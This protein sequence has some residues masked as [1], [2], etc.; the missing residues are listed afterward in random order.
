MRWVLWFVIGAW[1]IFLSAMAVLH[2][3]I[4][5][6]IGELRPELEIRASQA[7]GIPLRIGSIEARPGGIFPSFQLDNV[8]LLDP[9]GHDALRLPRVM[10][11]V[12]PTS[13]WNLG[14]EHL[15]IDSPQL[16]IRRTA[17]GR[18]YV[19]GLDVSKDQ[20]SDGRAADWFFSQNE[21]VIQNGSVDWTDELRNM[22]TLTLEQVN[23]VMQNDLRSHEMRLDASPPQA[24]SSR[25]SVK[26]KFSQPLLQSHAGQWRDWSGQVYATFDRVDV[27]QLR[28]HANV[29]LA[30][31]TGQGAVRAWIDIARGQ[32]RGATADVALSNASLTLGRELDILA[33]SQ[34][35]GRFS[36][37][38]VGQGF[39]FSTAD[40]AFD[41]EDGLHWPGGNLSGVW[42]PAQE[43][44]PESGEFKAN[45]LDLSAL[46]QIAKRLPLDARV[47]EALISYAPKGL[48]EQL[49]ATWQ[50]APHALSK[51]EIKA[52]VQQLSVAAQAAR[53]VDSASHDLGATPVTRPPLGRPGVQGA[54][55][56]VTLNQSGGQATV[57]MQNGQVEF[58]GVFEKP[59]IEL[60]QLAAEVK[61][62][63]KEDALSVQ[64]PKLKFANADAQ[65]E[66]Q[67][68]WHTSQAGPGAAHTVFPGVLDM[69][70][71]LTRAN[72]A[73]LYRYLPVHIQQNVRDYLRDAITAGHATGVNFK[74]KGNLAD[75]PFSDPHQGEF[76]VSGLASD[77]AYAY[78]PRTQQAKEALPWPALSQA[79]GE[80]KFQGNS[81]TLKNVTARIA[82]ANS[83]QILHGGAAIT[84][85]A[86]DPHV[87]VSL[88]AQGPL[89]DLLRAG[90][91]GSPLG[92]MLGQTLSQARATGNAEL[93]L[94]LELP[95][96]ALDS[97]KVQGKVKLLSNEVQLSKDMPWLS[98]TSGVVHFS[99]QG[100]ALADAT[101]RTLGGEVRAEGG[102]IAIPGKQVAGASPLLRIQGTL[103]AE[104]LRQA[105]ELGL[106]SQLA[107]QASGK[108]SYT[109]SLNWRRGLPEW[110][111]NSSLQGL[112]LSLP[113]PLTKRAESALPLRLD[114]TPTGEPRQD[115]LSLDIG[116]AVL[117]RYVRDL[118]GPD[119]KVLRGSVAV[120]LPVGE[121][122]ALPSQGVLA[123]ATLNRLDVDAL[124][125]LM[126]RPSNTPVTPANA[127]SEAIRSYLPSSVVVQANE[128]IAGGHTFNH[129]VAG[130][131]RSGRAWQANVDATE[132]S[133]YVEYTESTD[134]RAGRVYARL[135]RLM[136]A[137]SGASEVE[138]LLDEQPVSIPTLDVVVDELELRGK[139]LGRLEMEAVNRGNASRD[140]GAREWRLNKLNVISREASF[141][142]TG[143]WSVLN[144]PGTTARAPGARVGRERRR[145]VMNFKMNVDDA[146]GML[147][148]IGMKDV[149]RRGNGFME[150]QVSWMGSPMAL[151]YPS[152][153]GAFNVNIEN[154]QFLKA[155][156][157]AA[158]LLG[159]LNLQA[160]PRRLTL[161]F[162]DVFSDG[163]SFDYVRG[164]VRIDQGI[165]STQNL[166]MQGVNAAVF[167]EGRADIARETQDIK[168]VVVPEINAG[169]ASLI[170][171][172][173]NP[174]VGLSTF[175][176]QLILR[177]PLIESNTQ[178]FKLTGTWADPIIDR[179]DLSKEATTPAK[180]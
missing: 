29:T 86:H 176:A 74:V 161:D 4:V 144:E 51:Y 98:R 40:M 152:L 141:I 64:V 78:V 149:F 68:S 38:R 18:I 94:K 140:A 139:K 175:L 145:T 171:G 128:V 33:M 41:T 148:R 16:H 125:S 119:A 67:A 172:W 80:F 23:L 61:W 107:Q 165:A 168:V 88:E 103:T 65:G 169:T 14:F 5:P 20:N 66:A 27:A 70:G 45:R 160:L 117:V 180:P 137:S 147:A 155:D 77:V 82:N 58:P 153:S 166:Q 173:A 52:R 142:A 22:P 111:V 112:S 113:Q 44:E 85:M 57:S 158:K 127:S 110:S 146:G 151:D 93:Q 32:L 138:N 12:S 55:L 7:L 48:V 108:T 3:V 34:F 17:Q 84:D 90:V 126:G 164:N 96:A 62:Q 97:T 49:Q 130:A 179:I 106:V 159:V 95:L 120:G 26:A 177:K 28:Q 170:A 69:Q 39:A 53:R 131:S 71:T 150:G 75:M 178:E 11:T 8:R 129:L 13:L 104:G 163:F 99:E 132:L 134:A 35:S 2:W 72:P 121:V 43:G 100:F 1:L 25:V 174:I 167:M 89:N 143:N 21:F 10:A 30:H 50:G 59:L 123:K 115:L 31:A 73:R 136:L 101:A 36:G 124:R 63:I 156:P 92:A 157:G 105:R 162:R 56:D 46:A 91:S 37:K 81:L 19:A 135:A 54:N 79:S 6:R 24:L 87:Q 47:H 114:I 118:S 9:D 76:S 116:R 122:L 60:S 15:Y 42:Q 83:V 109:A 133:G 102:S 154:G